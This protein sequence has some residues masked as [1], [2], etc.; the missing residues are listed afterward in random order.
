MTPIFTQPITLSSHAEGK[1]LKPFRFLDLPLE[2]RFIV[3][4]QLDIVTRSHV[5]DKTNAQDCTQWKVTDSTDP[6]IT[7][8][9]KALPVAILAT[10]R[11]IQEEA[12]Q[13]LTPR[14][15]E[16]EKEPVRFHLGYGGVNALTSQSS[17]LG[18][19]FTVDADSVQRISNTHVRDFVYRCS[20]YLARTRQVPRDNDHMDH[21]ELIVNTS[22]GM[23]KIYGHEV[24]FAIKGAFRLAVESDLAV[25][26]TYRRTFPSARLLDRLYSGRDILWQIIKLRI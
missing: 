11:L 26:F 12:T 23:S 19:C 4:A 1:P 18:G 7:L 5:L 20:S 8:T 13:V 15:R 22:G 17:L 10:C 24:I 9:R 2:L 25:M 16:L 21:I 14:L 6:S 3:Y